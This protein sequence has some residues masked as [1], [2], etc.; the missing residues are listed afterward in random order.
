MIYKVALV[1]AESTG[2]TTLA[3]ALAT[4]FGTSWNPEFV[5]TFAD[6]KRQTSSPKLQPEDLQT[7]FWGQWATEMQATQR[8]RPPF[9]FLDTNLLMSIVY[10]KYYQSRREEWWEKA[11][12]EQDYALYFLL[13]DDFPWVRDPQRE[14]P[15][16]RTRLQQ[17][18]REELERRQI[19]FFR[20]G[21][22]QKHRLEQ[23][24]TILKEKY[25]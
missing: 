2:K 3:K 17:Q 21:G 22:N 7:I 14:G 12:Q 11:F 15:Q 6:L 4:H 16:I 20:I 25:G 24:V 13:E 10:A 5:R 19:P 1:G 18:I 23:A 8:A 9:T